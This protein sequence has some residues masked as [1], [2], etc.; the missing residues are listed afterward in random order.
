MKYILIFCE[1][2]FV[3]LLHLFL[4]STQQPCQLCWWS[5]QKLHKGIKKKSNSPSSGNCMFMCPPPKLGQTKRLLLIRQYWED[6]SQLIIDGHPRSSADLCAW[7]GQSDLAS[8]LWQM[9]N[10]ASCCHLH[11]P[12]PSL[13]LLFCHR[14]PRLLISTLPTLP[15][16][17]WHNWRNIPA[18]WI[19]VSLRYLCPPQL[20]CQVSPFFLLPPFLSVTS[21]SSFLLLIISLPVSVHWNNF[22]HDCWGKCLAIRTWITPP[23]RGVGRIL[24]PVIIIVVGVGL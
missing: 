13:A 1:V 3:T 20:S 4:G 5:T 6:N 17:C 2:S 19:C 12:W 21:F 18:T 8:S 22:L 15:L 14:E 7:C 16:F 11:H 10:L 23:G 9:V 24:P